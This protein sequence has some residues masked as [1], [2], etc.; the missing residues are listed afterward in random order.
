VEDLSQVDP[1]SDAPPD[2]APT[3]RVQFDRKDPSKT[4]PLSWAVEMLQ[5][6]YEANPASFSNKLAGVVTAWASRSYEDKG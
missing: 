1:W 5:R 6:Q 2:W 3:S 4:I